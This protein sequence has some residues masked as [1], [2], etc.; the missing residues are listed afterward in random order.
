M[1]VNRSASI[2]IGV[3]LSIQMLSPNGT[4]ASKS[5][6]LSWSLPHHSFTVSK[7]G[8]SPTIRKAAASGPSTSSSVTCVLFQQQHVLISSGASD[9]WAPLCHVLSFAVALSKFL[10]GERGCLVT[11]YSSIPFSPWNF[12]QGGWP[13]TSSSLVQSDGITSHH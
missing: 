12:T 9:G 13:L 7:S 6:M 2:T 5:C 1:L 10:Q 4:F 8:M 3:T 11:Y